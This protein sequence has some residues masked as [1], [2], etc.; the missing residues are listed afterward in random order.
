MRPVGMPGLDAPL[1]SAC[2]SVIAPARFGA[3]LGA[4]SPKHF[5][6]RREFAPAGDLLSGVRQKGGKE[7]TPLSR[8][9]GLPSLRLTGPAGR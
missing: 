1:D 3:R 7:R 6:P 2:G 9:C 5:T 8:P 4:A